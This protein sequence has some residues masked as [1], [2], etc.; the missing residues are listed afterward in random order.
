MTC[1]PRVEYPSF[2]G[3]AFDRRSYFRLEAYESEEKALDT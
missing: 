1:D 2:E 3:G